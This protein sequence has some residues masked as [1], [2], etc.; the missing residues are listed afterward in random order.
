MEIS[1][2]SAPF[3][4]I[5]KLR[6]AGIKDLRHGTIAPGD[7]QFVQLPA[8]VRCYAIGALLA[9]GRASASDRLIGD[10]LVP[11]DSALGA[12]STPPRP[13]LFRLSASGWR[14]GTGHLDLLSKP[15]VYRQLHQWFTEK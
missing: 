2:Y 14:T 5:G 13:W 10:G 4:R 8:D 1:P 6:S 11:L 7:H 15:E 12:T 3:T 9:T